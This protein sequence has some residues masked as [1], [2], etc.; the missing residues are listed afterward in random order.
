MHLT[1]CSFNVTYAFQSESTLYIC[2]NLNELL[3]CNKRDIP[4][5]SDCNGTRTHNHLVC[6]RTLKQLVKVSKWFSWIVSTY[7]SGA[8]DC[9]FL[10]CLVRL[11]EWINILYL[12]ECQGTI[13]PFG[14]TDQIIEL[15][16]EYSSLRCI[17]LYVFIMSH[18]C[19]RV[20]LHSI[21]SWCQELLP[22]NRRDMWNW[23]YC[24]GARTHNHL[25]HKGT[26]NHLAKLTKS[27]SWIVSPYLYGAFDSMFLSYHLRVSEWIY[28][29][30]LTE[31]EGT[32]CS[33]QAWYL[34]F[35]WL[36]RSSNQQ[37]LRSLTSTQPFGQTD[38]MIEMIWEYWSQ[39]HIWLYVLIISRTLF[40]ANLHSIF[41]WM[42]RNCLLETDA[43]SEV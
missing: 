31:S 28:T 30:Y 12:P 15:N 5:W 36:P 43:I 19:F 26:L 7:L 25:V 27:F 21:F 2:L 24:N 17:S 10:S 33:R 16:P 35:K 20:N 23:S 1:V 14:Q 4:R 29:L 38:K 13:P 11:S 34:K 9:M 3:A 42:S 6:R 37:P 39:R 32:P 8:F 22:R 40:R 41:D 18:T